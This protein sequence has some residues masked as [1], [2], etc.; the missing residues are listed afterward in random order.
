[1]GEVDQATIIENGVQ[2]VRLVIS[3]EFIAV[4]IL[5]SL[6]LMLRLV[7]LGSVP[8]GDDEASQALSA[9][10]SV[11]PQAPGEAI[12][13]DS[14]VLFW[15]QRVSFGLLGSNA[16]LARFWT[17]LAGIALSISPLLFRGLLGRSRAYLFAILLTVSPVM[18]TASRFSSGA[19]WAMLFAVLG[20]W[21]LWRYWDEE[22]DHSLYGTLAIVAF[23]ALLFLAEPGG[24]ILA[25]ILSGAGLIVLFIMPLFA[26][27]EQDI[28]G[29]DWLEIVRERFSDWPWTSGLFVSA[30]TIVAVSTGFMLLPD[31]LRMLGALLEEFLRGFVHSQDTP[32]FFP[33]IVSLF[34]EPW[35]W[36]LTVISIVMIYRRS[37]FTFAEYFLLSW[38]GVGLVASLFYAGAEA[39]HGLWLIVPLA[40]LASWSVTDALVDYSDDALLFDLSL[41]GSARWGKWLLAVGVFAVLVVI[42]MQFQVVSRFFLKVPDGSLADFLERVRAPKPS[43]AMSLLWMAA[44]FIVLIFGSFTAASFWGNKVIWQGGLLGIF[45]FLLLSS[46]AVG[47]NVA[48]VNSDDPVELWHNQPVSNDVRLLRETLLDLSFRETQGAPLISI[49]VV[50]EGD[51]AIAW[52]LRDFSNAEFVQT[53]RDAQTA[54][55]ILSPSNVESEDVPDLGGSYVGQR[56]VLHHMWSSA[57][58]QGWDFLAWWGVRD[59]RFAP[60]SA[61]EIV[62][63]VR[64]DIYDSEPFLANGTR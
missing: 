30:L 32:A 64:Q 51:N 12:I 3:G 10:R 56:V 4:L 49:A 44:M 19:I 23:G 39:A 54:E 20:L 15:T 1:M 26:P 34:Y 47:W 31:G 55:V 50:A 9:W 22:N 25:L 2:P 24:P 27:D 14:P 11:S 6:S 41:D 59:V 17:A 21:A 33:F 29:D 35:L 8:V 61:G 43:P 60:Q 28:P 40:G 63:W 57:S 37:A 46:V 5:I 62:L 58:M 16:A 13:S 36:G 53:L 38:V 42:A 7:A 48:V 52:Q 45:I 18:L